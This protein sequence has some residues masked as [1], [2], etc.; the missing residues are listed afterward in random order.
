[1]KFTREDYNKRIVDLEG[2]IPQDEPVFLLRAQDKFSSVTLKKYCDFLEEEAKLSNNAH[3]AEM[4]AELREHAL[5]MLMWK[6][7]HVPDK[8]LI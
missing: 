6:Y 3:L 7:S 5:A 8:P 2:K 4:A 1:M